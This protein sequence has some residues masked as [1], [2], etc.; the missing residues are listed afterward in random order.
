VPTILSDTERQ[1]LDDGAD[2]A[3]YRSPRF[4]THADDGF[5]DRLTAL[6]AEVT[7]PGDRLFDAMSSWVSFLPEY[8]FDYVVGHGLYLDA[9]PNS[10]RLQSMPRLS[11]R[12]RESITQDAANGAREQDV[13]THASTVHFLEDGPRQVGPTVQM[14]LGANAATTELDISGRSDG[15]YLYAVKI[16]DPYPGGST[17]ESMPAVPPWPENL[18]W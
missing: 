1:K 6:Y 11:G 3:F 16:A 7:S 14:H 5:L 18:L 12:W 13:T 2:R 10:S 9:F 8:E 15:T 4:V 17:V